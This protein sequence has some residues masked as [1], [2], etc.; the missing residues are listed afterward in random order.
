MHIVANEP[1]LAF[2]R[3]QEHVRKS[4]PPMV[5]NR[6]EVIKL[7]KELQGH[8]YDVE[9]A[10]SAVK[11]ME[12]AAPH[13]ENMKDLIKTA[14]SY[15][16]QLKLEENRKG[17]KESSV[18]KRLS[19]HIPLDLPDLPELGNALRETANRVESMM[20]EAR[21]ASADH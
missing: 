16:Q 21:H 11:S 7:H 15:K 13:F 12:D 2:Y 19:A 18:Y 9:Y 14:T 1:S 17:K 20:A 4:L 8:C 10:V 5:E 3:L 6:V